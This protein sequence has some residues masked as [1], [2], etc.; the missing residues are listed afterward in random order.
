MGKDSEKVLLCGEW[1]GKVAHM[2]RS[3]VGEFEFTLD[4]KGRVAIPARLRPE[5]SEGIFVTRGFD[6]C[7]SGYAPDEWERFVAEQTDDTSAMSSKG[8]QL[9]RFISASANW[10]QLDGQGRIKVSAALL[11]FASIAKD[12]TIIG[13]QDHIEIWDRAVWAEYRKHME[14]EADATADE[15]ATS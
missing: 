5:F 15:L 7:L 10:E 11:Q 8:R 4:A 13:V 1:W 3:L 12:V 2:Q 6:R 9:R 14:E